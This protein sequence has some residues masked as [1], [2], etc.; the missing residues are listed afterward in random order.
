MQ[1]HSLLSLVVAA[2]LCGAMFAP[3]SH[4]QPKEVAGKVTHVTLYRGQAQV[5]RELSVEG[6]VGAI[7]VVVTNLPAKIV[8]SSLFAESGDAAGVEVRSVQ[9]R[10]RAVGQEP[11][12]E[13]RAIDEKL[14]AMGDELMMVTSEIDVIRQDEEHLAK[15]QAFEINAASSDAG[16]GKLDADAL[17]KATEF[18]F[19]QRREMARRRVE[20]SRTVRDLNEQQSLLQRQRGELTRGA[21]RT[22]HEAVVFLEKRAAGAA[23]VRLGYLVSDCGWSPS[24][25]FRADSENGAINI[26]Y[27]ALIQQMSGEDWTNVKL[28]LLTASPSLSAAGASLAPLPVELAGATAVNTSGYADQARD[29]RARQA[30]ANTILLGGV[31]RTDNLRSNWEMNDAANGL[32][33]MELQADKDALSEL[34]RVVENVEEGPSMSYELKA[35]VTLAS[36]ADQ[37]MLRILNASSA[38]DFY[39]V[40]TPMLGGFVYREASMSNDTEQDLLAGPVTVYMDGRFVGRSEIGTVARNQSFSIGLGADSQ[41]RTSRELVK[42]DDRQQG[43]NQLQQFAYR[44]VVES[45]KDKAVPVRIYERV[46]YSQKTGELRV[47]VS[48][49]SDEPSTDATYLRLEKPKGILRWD[50]EVPANAVGAEARW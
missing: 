49:M 46:P 38:A 16:N 50:V 15:L 39:Y 13:I 45:Y 40:A 25:N 12:Q 48:D 34:R 10:T 11:R 30:Q 9:Y 37:Q 7:E 47:M 17:A 35:P 26:E 41:L 27:N 23:T 36:R 42:R 21:T 2:L 24:Y 14:K 28:T 44:L 3:L 33:M 19:T 6:P 43:G 22:E 4:A 8:G 29:L 20:L 31:T 5:M 18:I 1:R 32:Q